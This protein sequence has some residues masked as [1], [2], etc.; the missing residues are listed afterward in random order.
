[1]AALVNELLDEEGLDLIFRNAR[2]H[3]VWL[4]EPVPE[5][6]LRAIWDA[7]KFGPT[8]ANCS[9]LR[10]VFVQ[11][12]EAKERLVAC[13]S[14][15]NQAK[16]SVAPVTAILAMDLEFYEEMPRL[17]PHN[18]TARSWFAGKPEHIKET[19]L[20]NSSLQGAYFIIAAR[21]LGLD[22]G[23]MSGFNAEKVNAEFFADGTWKVNF[24]CS[25]GHGDAGKL[26]RRSPRLDFDEACRIA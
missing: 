14:E 13:M 4:P 16:T 5:E 8:S 20:R 17:F 24:V 9:P 10:I 2:T 15:N 6:K 25:L 11:S 7:M 19:A 12:A 22:C 1:M 23:P 26:F 3:N 18:Q 21:S